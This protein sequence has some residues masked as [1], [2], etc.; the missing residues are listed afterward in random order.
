MTYVFRK[1]CE[2]TL[3]KGIHSLPK[4]CFLKEKC[5]RGSSVTIYSVLLKRNICHKVK[6]VWKCI[7]IFTAGTD[8]GIFCADFVSSP[9][10]S[11][12][13]LLCLKYLKIIDKLDRQ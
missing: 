8:H 11:G 3:A 9:R 13:I 6:D 7:Q 10:V 1:T 5:E 12:R 4:V 2:L